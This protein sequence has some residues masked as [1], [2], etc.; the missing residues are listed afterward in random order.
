M[1]IPSRLH[2]TADLH[3]VSATKIHKGR[4]PKAIKDEAMTEQR[5][6]VSSNKSSTNDAHQL[7][8]VSYHKHRP[9]SP[10]SS[11]SFVL[12]KMLV[13]RFY[14]SVYGVTIMTLLMSNVYKKADFCCFI[15]S[16]RST[17]CL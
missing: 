11:I 10:L 7:Q 6:S 4:D 15:L 14:L 12:I 2:G 1:G 3:S 5:Q 17:G 9:P 8:H 13:I 16:I